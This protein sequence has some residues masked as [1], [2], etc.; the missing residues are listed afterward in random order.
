MKR[1][2]QFLESL[3][4]LSILFF[5]GTAIASSDLIVEFA[6]PAWDGKKIPQG[7][8]CKKDGGNGS[9]PP[10]KVSNIPAEADAIIL[11]IN[12]RDYQ[13]LSSKGGH[14]RIGFEIEP[15]TKSVTLPAVPG[16]TKEMPEGVWIV[17]K[18]RG[19]GAW[20]SQGY[21]PPCSGGRGNKYEAVVHAV[22]M[23]S[24]KKY[25]KI[26]KARIVLGKY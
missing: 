10:L 16:G 13:P 2:P 14:G 3:L 4:A 1:I 19:S 22:V 20:R 11:E 23:K 18:N 7:Q 21:L 5:F 8:H 26:S 9:T 12:D 24:K 25:D 15:G 17:K 6:D